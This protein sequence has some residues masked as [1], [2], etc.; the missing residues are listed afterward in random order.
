M[1]LVMNPP[2]GVNG[3]QTP[4]Q[5]LQPSAAAPQLALALADIQGDVIIGLQKKWQRFVFFSI[6]ADVAGFKVALRGPV[7]RDVTSAERA[8]ERENQL[9]DHKL[10]GAPRSVPPSGFLIPMTGLNVAFTRSGLSKLLPGVSLDGPGLGVLARSSADIARA[11]ADRMNGPM[12]AEWEPAFL[13]AQIDGVFLIT[14]AT[15]DEVDAAWTKLKAEL[16]P[17]AMEVWPGGA[18]G[19]VRPGTAAGHEHFGWQ[20]GISQPAVKGIADPFPGQDVVPPGLFVFGQEGAPPA[21]FPWMANGSLMVFRKLAQA[22]AE[23]DQFLRDEG[24]KLG[25]DPAL[26]GARMMGRWKSGAPLALAPL[27]DDRE[28]GGR[29]DRN[30]DF[31]FSD[32]AGQRRCPFGSHIR[33]TNPRS[34]LP[35]QVQARRIMRAGIPYGPEVADAP[36]A[37]RGL[38]FVC[39]QTSIES[40]FE[41]VQASWSNNTGF[42][43]GKTRPSIPTGAFSVPAPPPGMPQLPV[44]VTVGH[45][46]IIGQAGGGPRFMD[47]PVPN[48]PTGVQRSTLPLARQFVTPRA[49]LYLFVPSISALT[50]PLS[51]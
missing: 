4:Q 39:Y 29:A 28:L 30:N 45:D 23:F 14:G 40:Q 22:V 5:L 3:L 18:I 33:K 26:L 32:D 37:E 47:E 9:R 6:S 51:A 48:Y 38:L 25:T 42:A 7:A 2:L 10:A 27:Q 50:G 17:T 8:R 49:G 34:D 46:P 36:G 20:D 41:F 19:N 35:G 43:S 11:C 21:P 15:K 16:G 12:P 31:D 44:A 24:D 1:V 13:T